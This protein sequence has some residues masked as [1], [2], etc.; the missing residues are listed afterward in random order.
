[1]HTSI[2]G[3][4]DANA[5]EILQSCTKSSIYSQLRSFKKETVGNFGSKH[6]CFLPLKMSS[7]TRGHVCP[8]HHFTKAVRAHKWNLAKIFFVAIMIIMI[9]SQI[10][11]AVVTN[12][13][14][15]RSEVFKQVLH[16]FFFT[17]FGLLFVKWAPCLNGL[18]A[19]S[20]RCVF[21]FL[22]KY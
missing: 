19:H 21:V 13:D 16:V 3:D 22:Y 10:C 4:I 7:D 11:S 14:P 12:R 8:G 18:I 6:W 15:I 1:M 5:M 17:R 20:G 9:R 2:D